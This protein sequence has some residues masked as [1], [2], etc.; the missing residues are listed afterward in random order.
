MTVNGPEKAIEAFDNCIVCYPN[1]V[2]IREN[3]GKLLYEVEDYE[4]SLE[5][6]LEG[7]RVDPRSSK[8]QFGAGQC[9]L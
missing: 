1:D 7:I 9:Y 4:R 2:E 6:Y 5:Q 8:A 3:F